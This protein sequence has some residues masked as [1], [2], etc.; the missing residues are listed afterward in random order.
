MPHAAYCFVV[1]NP[2][3]FVGIRACEYPMQACNVGNELLFTFIYFAFSLLLYWVVYVGIFGQL[4]SVFTV[5]SKR[6]ELQ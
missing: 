3:H 1:V 4:G 5:P 2:L 6:K